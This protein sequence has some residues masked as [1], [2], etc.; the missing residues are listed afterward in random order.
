M[1]ATTAPA[2]VR[3]TL[4]RDRRESLSHDQLTRTIYVKVSAD[5]T[6][7][8]I[9]ANESCELQIDDGGTT[10]AVNDTFFRPALRQGKAVEGVARVRLADL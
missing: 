4:P 8:G 7:L 6:P 10:A 2:A 5:G 3:G 9:F 1:G